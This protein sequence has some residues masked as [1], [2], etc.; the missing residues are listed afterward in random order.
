M[1]KISMIALGGVLLPLLSFSAHAD[2]VAEEKAELAQLKAQEIKADEES[3]V[4]DMQ[5]EA[6]DEKLGDK[7]A[8]D[9]E[10]KEIEDDVRELQE[11]L[12][13]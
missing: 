12:A 2:Q 7:A 13:H 6:L 9:Y 1:L 5:E 3:L 10:K 11:D 4:R 8:A